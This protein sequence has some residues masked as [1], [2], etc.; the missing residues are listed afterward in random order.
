MSDSEAVKD[1]QLSIGEG[2]SKAASM[3]VS[4]GRGKRGRK[5]RRVGERGRGGAGRGGR[6]QGRVERGMRNKMMKVTTTSIGE[7]EFS[8]SSSSSD[9]E[10][11]SIVK[12]LESDELEIK[13][14][15]T[16]LCKR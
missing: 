13:L 6:G 9:S 1:D 2:R 16:L 5:G 8:A 12:S 15:L 7:L 3:G 11:D 14:K 10:L 4:R